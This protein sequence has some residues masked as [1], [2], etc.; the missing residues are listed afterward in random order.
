[1]DHGRDFLTL[2]KSLTAMAPT[3]AA[4]RSAIS[5]AYYAAQNFARHVLRSFGQSK[6]ADTMKSHGLVWRFLEQSGDTDFRKVAQKLADL[7]ADR[8]GADYHLDK[9][10]FEKTT[11]AT[12]CINRAQ[13]IIADLDVNDAQREG[14]IQ[15]ALSNYEKIYFNKK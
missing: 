12:Q 9:A 8:V 4:Q 7:E 5:R 10:Q 15:T 1:M 3:D 6:V 2:A 13:A 14:K 11:K